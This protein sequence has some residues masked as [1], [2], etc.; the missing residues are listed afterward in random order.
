VAIHRSLLLFGSPANE[1]ELA[2][3][4]TVSDDLWRAG[5]WAARWL[6]Q[7]VCRLTRKLA[8]RSGRPAPDGTHSARA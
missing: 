3:V 1:A 7:A 8:G 2:M 4:R 6:L 5:A